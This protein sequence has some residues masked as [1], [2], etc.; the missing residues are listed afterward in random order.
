MAHVLRSYDALRELAKGISCIGVGTSDVTLRL[1]LTGFDI[2]NFL[3]PGLGELAPHHAR[4]EAELVKALESQSK[5]AQAVYNQ[6]RE[7]WYMTEAGNRNQNNRQENL[8]I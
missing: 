6:R 5:A 7:R 2:L 4:S 1:S 3:P 8:R